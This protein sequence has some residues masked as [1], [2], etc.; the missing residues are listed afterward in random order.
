MLDDLKK[1][2]MKFGRMPKLSPEQIAY[3]REQNGKGKRHEDGAALLSVNR[4]THY[5][6]LAS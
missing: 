5:R 4:T 1:R 3:A 2:G 6:A